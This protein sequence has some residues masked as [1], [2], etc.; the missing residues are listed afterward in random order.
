MRSPL[1]FAFL[2]LFV[3]S[4][5]AANPNIEESWDYYDIKGSTITKLTLQMRF[6]GPISEESRR[7]SLSATKKKIKISGDCQVNLKLTYRLPRW[8][9]RDQA[10]AA[11]RRKWDS[12]YTALKRHELTHG[13][14]FHAA[15]RETV[16]ADCTGASKIWRKWKG[17]TLKYDQ[18][19]RGGYL[20]GVRLPR[21]PRATSLP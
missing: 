14:H 17:V 9:N 2:D 18:K 4:A 13:S 11:V 7:P 21:I 1:T 15:A 12:F 8:V 19:T 16:A 3:V 5:E 6:A 20:E 10:P